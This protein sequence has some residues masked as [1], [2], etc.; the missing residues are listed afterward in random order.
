MCKTSHLRT[1]YTKESWRE[2]MSPTN[3]VSG[4]R[5]ARFTKFAASRAW[6]TRCHA[7][8]IHLVEPPAY[9]RASVRMVLVVV[10]VLG[11]QVSDEHIHG[12]LKSAVK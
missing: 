1:S 5:P 8:T 7:K 2:L 4:D 3:K 12:A 9:L 11:D 6:K 10:V